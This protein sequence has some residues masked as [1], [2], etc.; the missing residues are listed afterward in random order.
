MP[1]TFFDSLTG[2]INS[3]HGQLVLVGVLAE[4]T[5]SRSLSEKYCT[6][7]LKRRLSRSTNSLRDSLGQARGERNVPKNACACD[8]ERKTFADTS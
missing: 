7:H 4:G 3:P 8:F 6:L 1:S 2:F 5:F